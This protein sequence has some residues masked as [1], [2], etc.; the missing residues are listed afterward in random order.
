MTRFFII[1][2]T[3]LRTMSPQNSMSIEYEPIQPTQSIEND[4]DTIQPT[5]SIECVLETETQEEISNTQ[6]SV[7][8][9]DVCFPAFPD[10]LTSDD[11]PCDMKDCV[12]CNPL[13]PEVKGGKL[14]LCLSCRYYTEHG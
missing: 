12:G 13:I 6:E 2:R 9:L 14:D 7:S 1:Q 5:Q 11:D 4:T 3:V 10:D 8:S